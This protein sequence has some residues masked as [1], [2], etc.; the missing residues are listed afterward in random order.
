VYLD[1]TSLGNDVLIMNIPTDQHTLG[2]VLFSAQRIFCSC[3][4]VCQ[5]EIYIN[6]YGIFAYLVIMIMNTSQAFLRY[7]LIIRKFEFG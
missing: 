7:F 2:H 5:R 1:R 6:G 4:E 3:I